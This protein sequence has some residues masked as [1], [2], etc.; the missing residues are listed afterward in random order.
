M[1][2]LTAT[3]SDAVAAAVVVPD[4]VAPFAGA[5]IVT[6]GR[7]WSGLFAAAAVDKLSAQTNAPTKARS[8]TVSSQLDFWT[9]YS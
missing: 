6:V 2:W 4:T 8:C 1:T 3:L 9:P 7:V 5:L